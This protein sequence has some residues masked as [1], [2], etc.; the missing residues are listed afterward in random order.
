MWNRGRPSCLERNR[1]IQ[2]TRER[3]PAAEVLTFPG[4]HLTASERPDL[5]AVAIGDIAARHGVGIS[6]IAH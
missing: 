6:C 5:L 1:Q 2:A 3:L 4:G